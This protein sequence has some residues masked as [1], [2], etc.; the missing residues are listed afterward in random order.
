MGGGVIRIDCITLFPEMFDAVAQWGITRKALESGLWTLG[1]WNPR[2]FVEDRYRTV[3]DRP[4]GGGPGMVMM[5]EPLAKAIRAAKD[6]A[7]I[8][9][10]K[11][12]YLSP[13]GRVL[14][15]PMAQRLAQEKQLVLLCGRYE[16]V[17]ERL[18]HQMVDEEVSLGDYVIS[19][20][21]LAAMVLIDAVVRLLPGALG[22]DRSASQD[23]F[24]MSGGLLDCPHYTRPE[25]WEGQAVPPVLLSGNH[26]EIDRW[27]LKQSLG[28]TWQRR[29]E[30]LQS[31]GMSGEES[32]LLEEFQRETQGK[33][34]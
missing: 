21:D 15:Q 6:S 31:R 22:D 12:V 19:G 18:V 32:R 5:A 30:L 9:G 17:D 1:L 25:R 28:R 27:R 4:Y 10:G 7:G 11:V 24:S 2:E 13:Q 34:Q 29:P 14:D 33:E 16:G 8:V 3:D 20:G 26:A 23:S